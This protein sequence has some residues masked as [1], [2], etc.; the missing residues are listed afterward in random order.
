MPANAPACPVTDDQA[1]RL[2]PVVADLLRNVPEVWGEFNAD[3]LTATQS[4]ALYLLTAAGMIERRSV[5]RWQIVGSPVVI[6]ATLAYTGD[7]GFSEA[8]EP[9]AAE[10]W[11]LWTDHLAAGE[12]RGGKPSRYESVG[13]RKWRLTEHGIQARDDLGDQSK[14]KGVFDWVMRRGLFDGQRRVTI[15]GHVIHL[16]QVESYGRVE[17]LVVRNGTQEVSDV[18]VSNHADIGKSVAK[19]LEPYLEGLRQLAVKRDDMATAGNGGVEASGFTAK[20]DGGAPRK[21]AEGAD[22]DNGDVGFVAMTRP[23]RR[24]ERGTARDKLIASL[25]AHHSYSTDSCLVD[26]PIGCNELARQASAAPSTA[27]AF[28]KD[29]F[30]GWQEYRELCGNKTSLLAALKLLNDEFTPRHL[31]RRD[32]AG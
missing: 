2:W 12:Y 16:D 10:L 22:D 6:E 9:V 21:Q 18:R 13:P 32:V 26:E 4:R 19:A 31:L 1:A 17:R 14:A 25:T 11:R 8:M 24:T 27:S 28:F 7:S 23:T 20:A 3:T 29:Q 30:G 5:G 15:T